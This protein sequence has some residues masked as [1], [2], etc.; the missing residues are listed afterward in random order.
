M[1]YVTPSPLFTRMEDGRVEVDAWAPTISITRELIECAD[2]QFVTEGEG[3]VRITVDNGWALYSLDPERWP[4]IHDGRLLE[5][6]GPIL[7]YNPPA[8]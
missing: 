2:P 1:T 7:G 4:S 8:R 6:E 5:H 3:W